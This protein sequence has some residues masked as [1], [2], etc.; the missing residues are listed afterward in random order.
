MRLDQPRDELG[1]ADSAKVPHLRIGHLMPASLLD[2]AETGECL[3]RRRAVIGFGQVYGDATLP[4]CI[5]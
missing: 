4:G 5:P 1:S 2:I 3:F